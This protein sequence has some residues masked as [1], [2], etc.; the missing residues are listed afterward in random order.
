MSLKFLIKVLLIKKKKFHPS[1]EDPKK[2]TSP[3]VPQNGAPIKTDT[4]F[5]SLT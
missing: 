5:Q 2:G 3:H 1:L 4:H